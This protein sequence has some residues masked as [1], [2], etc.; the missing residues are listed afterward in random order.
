VIE[1]QSV[2][3]ASWTKV[4]TLEPSVTTYTV[5]NLKDKS[6]LYFRVFAENVIGL[7]I[8]A[9]TSL[10]SLKTHASKYFLILH[11]LTPSFKQH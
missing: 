11:Q 10:V 4:V 3:E 8:P 9:T 2:T 5:E 6:E 7:S 1:K